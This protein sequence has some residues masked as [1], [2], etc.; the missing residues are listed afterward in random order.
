MSSTNC[1]AST[2]LHITSLVIA[3]LGVAAGGVVIVLE[4]LPSVTILGG[5]EGLVD[6]GVG[7]RSIC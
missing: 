5:G 1:R 4:P 2:T 7:T 3:S 6:T